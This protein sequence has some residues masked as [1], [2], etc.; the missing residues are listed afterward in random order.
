MKKTEKIMLRLRPDDLKE[1]KEAADKV[2]ENVTEYITRA[3]R[4]RIKKEQEG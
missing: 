4:Q 3:V 1:I 2:R